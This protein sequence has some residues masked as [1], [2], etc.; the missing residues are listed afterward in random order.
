MS[1]L[2]EVLEANQQYA[3]SFGEK[4]E[5]ALPPARHYRRRQSVRWIFARHAPC[6]H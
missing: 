5:L 6:R 4:G 1:V 3:A 2:D